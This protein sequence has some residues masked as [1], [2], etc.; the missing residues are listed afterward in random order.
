MALLT[1]EQLQLA[2][3]ICNVLLYSDFSE[4]CFGTDGTLVLPLF[5]VDKPNMTLQFVFLA[6]NFS[7]L[8][9]LTA[10]ILFVNSLS[11]GL[12]VLS[13]FKDGIAEVTIKYHFSFT[14]GEVL[15]LI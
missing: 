6:E 13:C 10:L 5:L 7:A 8:I 15:L 4:E 1:L 11:M 3:D 14:T 9:T 2:M 12:Y